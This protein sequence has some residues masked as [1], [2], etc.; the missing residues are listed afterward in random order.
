[1]SNLFNKTKGELEDYIERNQIQKDNIEKNI[2]KA[3]E[4]LDSKEDW[5][6]TI[7][8][9]YILRNLLL[10]FE[11]LN[12]SSNCGSSGASYNILSYDLNPLCYSYQ[13]AQLALKIADNYKED[14]FCKYPILGEIIGEIES[15][16][17][18]MDRKGVK[19]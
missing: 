9:P 14:D 15:L 13:L 12:I 10:I 19:I 8:K 3:K 1:M 5:I 18:E 11:S 2:S 4:I 7:D 16:K 17:M 6:D